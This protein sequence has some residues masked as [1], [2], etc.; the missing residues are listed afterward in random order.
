MYVSPHIHRMVRCVCASIH[1][2]WLV[3]HLR[4]RVNATGIRFV[5]FAHEVVKQIVGVDTARVCCELVITSTHLALPC[6]AL[7]RLSSFYDSLFVCPAYGGTAPYTMALAGVTVY[8]AYLSYMFGLT[9]CIYVLLINIST[10]HQ[11]HAVQN[12]PYFA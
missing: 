8:S 11:I 7:P 2:G 4:K 5:G 10:H 3:S 6:L 1:V 9:V 12:L